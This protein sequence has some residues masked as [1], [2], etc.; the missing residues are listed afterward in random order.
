MKR[1]HQM[2]M[3]Y[4]KNLIHA[5][6]SHDQHVKSIK[7]KLLLDEK[8]KDEIA[9]KNQIILNR[10]DQLKRT[11]VKERIEFKINTVD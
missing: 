4:T 7:T 11:K 8:I 9:C 10:Q 5:V 2:Y 3:V 6:Q 1:N